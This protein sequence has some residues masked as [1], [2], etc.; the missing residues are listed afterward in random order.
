MVSMSIERAQA[1]VESLNFEI[2]KN[3]LKFDQVLNQQRDV[4]YRWRRQLL[5]SENNEDLIF[6][7]RDD[8]IEDVQNSIENYKTQY[9]SLDE[10]RNYVDDELSLLLSDNVKKH[11]L[12][13]LELNDNLDIRLSLE[14]LYLKNLESDNENFKNLSRKDFKIVSKIKPSKKSF[15]NLIFAFNICRFVKSNAIV[16]VKEDS[17]VGIGSGQPSRIDSCKIAIKKMQN[18]QKDLNKSEII[19]ASDAFFPFIDGPETLAHSG[20]TTIVQP[21][22]SIRDKEIIKYANKVGMVL[23][24]SKTRHFKH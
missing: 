4:I 10:F 20:V 16:I 19:A 15:K 22:G 24:Y 8:V 2:R 11:L 21:F 5:R 18:F 3:V 7:W 17:T 6:E 14:N 13:D 12:K 1:Q 23:V 9:E